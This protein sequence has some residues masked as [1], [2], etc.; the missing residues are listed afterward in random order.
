MPGIGFFRESSPDAS[1]AIFGALRQGMQEAGFVEGQN[2]AI[3]YRWSERQYDQLPKLAP[4]L[5]RR[6]V[7]VIVAAGNDAAI[8]AK[9]ATTTIPIVFATGDDPVQMGIVASLN[10]PEGNV[11]GVTF[12]SGVLGKRVELLHELV[13]TATA[14]GLL[15]NPN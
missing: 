2:V 13:P 14:I 7:A 4:E 15:V 9:A 1:T 8:A 3:E 6:Q 5:V 12:Y 11:S 10:R